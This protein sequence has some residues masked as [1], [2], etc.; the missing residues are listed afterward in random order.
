MRIASTL[1][2]LA[3]LPVV[4]AS[5]YLFF[6]TLRS[7]RR[8]PPPYGSPRTRFQVVV[9]AH[10]ESAGIGETVK[11]LLAI[12]YPGDLF[13]VVVVADN[14]RDDTAARAN[15]AGARVLERSDDTLRGK[16]YALAHA[17]EASLAGGSV[18]AVV[19]VDADTIVSPNLL[20]AFDARIQSGATAV[21]ADYAV[22]NPDAGWR[23]RLMAVAFGMFH[24]VRSTG[25]ESLELS[26]GLRGNGM[27]FTKAV[28]EEVP[29]DAFSV[30]EDLE[31]GIR[32]G[33]HGHR[34]HYAGEAHVYG[35]MVSSERA[36]RSQ[37]ARWEGGR[38]QMVKQHAWPLLLRAM[39]ERNLLLAD[40]AVDLLV[41]PLSVLVAAT[42]AGTVAS[43]AL[44]V[45]TRRPNLALVLF[46]SSGAFLAVY[47]L[48]GWQ[49][50]G[51]GVRGLTS[52]GYAPFYMAWKA[53]LPLRR[54]RKASGDWVR[55]TRRGEAS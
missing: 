28:L 38:R 53:T 50:S 39:K 34:V 52:L 48:R 47:A 7:R 40:L 25:R 45:A 49:V 8:A 5:G 22:R 31:Y 42:A 18:D 54:T 17:F 15:A 46:G 32:L 19:V 36:S 1:L 12:D 44:A 23:T 13:E 20:R 43:A 33:E 4:G 24:V 3:A 41:P 30:V 55:T 10:N 9:P 21:Q 29:H 6:L 11:S 37:R 14:C 51:T 16:G 35:E 26:C 2:A 27:C